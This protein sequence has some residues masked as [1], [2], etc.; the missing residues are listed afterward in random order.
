MFE[1]AGTRIAYIDHSKFERRALYALGPLSDFDT[2]IVD[3][4]TAEEYVQALQRD[5]ANVIVAPDLTAPVAA[6]A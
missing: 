1:S 3:A 2:V 5:G 6:D 4:K